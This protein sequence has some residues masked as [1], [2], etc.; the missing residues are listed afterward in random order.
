M[1]SSIWGP[2]M[3]DIMF[4]TAHTLPVSDCISMLNEL[5]VVLPCSHC[6]RSYTAYLQRFD[7]EACINDAESGAKF[8]WTLHDF[9]NVKLDKRK[10]CIPF[11]LLQLRHAVFSSVCSY[12]DPLDMLAIISLQL[13]NMEQVESYCRIA[14]IFTKLAVVL[15]APPAC[16]VVPDANVCCPSNTWIHALSCRTKVRTA[17]GMVA[18]SRSDFKEHFEM[19]RASVETPSST[20]NDASSHRA[21]PKRSRRGLIR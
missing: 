9:V 15:G 20:E 1:N 11:S 10:A 6:R 19:C 3:W 8:I 7:P 13:E 4:T 21:R 5:R 12:W 18:E 17:L 2:K 14:P 16:N